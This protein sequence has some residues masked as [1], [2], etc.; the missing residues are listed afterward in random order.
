M[1]ILDG[2]PERHR[3]AAAE[4]YWQAFGGKLGRVLG[5]DDRGRDFVRRA[6][7]ADHVLAAVEGDRLLGICGFKTARGA[8]VAADASVMRASYGTLG[9]LWRRHALGLLVQDTDNE[10]FLIDGLCVAEGARNRGV[11]TALIGAIC[12]KARRQ[13][14]AAVRL[15]VVDTNLDARRLYERLGFRAVGMHRARAAATLFGFAA[16][17]TMVRTKRPCPD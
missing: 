1:K 12:T 15:D 11:G 7:R 17:V 13:G 8:F 9:A 10:R 4:L 5:P 6:I 2:L 14:Y 3:S 16:T